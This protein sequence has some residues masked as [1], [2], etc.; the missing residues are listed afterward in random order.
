V[1]GSTPAADDDYPTLL[2]KA[3]AAAEAGELDEAQDLADM[4]VAAAPDKPRGYVLRG[5]ILGRKR[6]PERAVKDFDEAIRLAP[7]LAEAWHHRG[8][9]QFK[10]G[11]FKES[12]AD[13]DRAIELQPRRKAGHWQRGI[14]YYYTGQFDEGA[15]QF[16][17]YQT[18]DDNDV[19]NVV[20]RYLC[21]ARRDGADAARSDLWKV[22]Q[23]ARVPMMEIYEVFAGRAKPEQVLAAAEA[24]D[25][26][27]E[28]RIR[29]RFY[30]HLYLGLYFDSADQKVEARKHLEK[31]VNDYM[32]PDYMGDV[33]RLHL[34][35]L[36]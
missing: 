14:S 26:P 7:N 22:G 9:E 30:G 10:L 29:R 24:G 23:D 5:T 21:M 32:V 17:A 12:V 3:G 13:F 34:K 25:V 8:C 20:W 31:A 36:E 15:R 4:A 35:S 27:D 1:A 2:A 18:V 28:E 6:L 19:E 11:K 33:A 16:E